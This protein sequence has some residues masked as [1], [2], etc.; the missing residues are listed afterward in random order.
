MYPDLATVKKSV[1]SMIDT[2]KK[3]AKLY[4]STCSVGINRFGYRSI[5]T[6]S[7][8]GLGTLGMTIRGAAARVV[9]TVVAAFA[10]GSGDLWSRHL[11][12][13]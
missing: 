12:S 3:K 6:T 5:T 13:R 1:T 4:A 9:S 10:P 8:S 7:F 11:V 2:P